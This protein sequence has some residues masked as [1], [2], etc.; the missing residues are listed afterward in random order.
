MKT[1]NKLIITSIFLSIMFVLAS[2]MPNVAQ[3]QYGCAYHSYQRCLGNNLYWYDSCGNQQD[4]AQYCQNGCYNNSCQNY[5]N[6]YNNC[7]YHAY[8]LC[9]GNSIYWYSGCNQQQDLF[10]TC[11]AGQTC[12]YGQCVAYIQP[13]QPNNYQ[14]YY[15]TACYGSSVYLYDSLGVISGL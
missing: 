13:I 11:L 14:P 1:I 5:Y 8:K 10:Y 9:V 4:L 12:Q 15:R 6:N 3:A 2:I 7:T